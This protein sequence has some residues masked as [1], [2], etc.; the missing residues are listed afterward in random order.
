MKKKKFGLA[1]NLFSFRVALRLCGKIVPPPILAQE[2]F[3]LQNLN[4]LTNKEI[5]QIL[6]SKP[7]KNLN[8]VYRTFKAKICMLIGAQE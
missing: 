3:F 6:K 8:L 1:Q 5:L 4:I 2:K 7:K